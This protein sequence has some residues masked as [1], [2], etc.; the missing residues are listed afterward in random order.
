MKRL[1]AIFVT[2]IMVTTL[3]VPTLS[4]LAEGEADYSDYVPS[5]DM[6]TDLV[7]ST[8]PYN[9]S[10][11][12]MTFGWS[13]VNS[14]ETQ[15]AATEDISCSASSYY[16]A[17]GTFIKSDKF[18]NGGLAANTSYVF[19]AKIK[20][21]GAEGTA[22]KFGIWYWGTSAKAFPVEYG[23]AGYAPGSEF[24]DY[25]VTI[26]TTDAGC[27]LGIGMVSAKSGDILQLDYSHGIYFAE[28]KE[29]EVTN[30]VVGSSKVFAGSSAT[31]DAKV[32]NQIGSTGTLNQDMSF[33]ALDAERTAEV[34]GFEFTP[35]DDGTTN[36][37][38]ADTVAVGTYVILAK[39][40]EYAGFQKGVTI[41][42]VSADAYADSVVGDMP[43]DLITNTWPFGDITV[44]MSFAWSNGYGSEAQW[45]ANSDMAYTAT[46]QT[47]SAG[48][49]TISSS[50]F[51]TAT[52]LDSN[53]SYVFS[54]KFKN[55]G[56]EGTNPTFQLY[57]SGNQGRAFST[58][59]GSEGWAPGREFEDYK[60]SFNTGASTSGPLVLGFVTASTG[61][62]IQMDWSEGMY[63]SEEAAYEL[64]NEITGDQMVFAG[65]STTLK[66]EVL[67]QLGIPGTLSQDVDYAVLNA[68]KTAFA[69]GITVTA[70]GDGTAKV[71][72]AA[73]AAAGTY[74][75]VA[76]TESGL[77]KSAQLDVVSAETFA[78]KTAEKPDNFVLAPANLTALVGNNG[79]GGTFERSL[80]SQQIFGYLENS[81][82]SDP[83]W[84]AG[85]TLFAE[86]YRNASFV[87]GKNYVVS[88]RLKNGAPDRK[89]TV[90]AAFAYAAN[91]DPAVT[92]DVSN[93]E[94]ETYASTFTAT[95]D[96][97]GIHFGLSAR[98][99]R[100]DV[101]DE[102]RG[103]LL[104]DYS[105]GGSL[106]V[107]EEVAYEVVN[108]ITGDAELL[109]GSS[110]T[111]KTEVL[112]QVGIK[113]NLAQDV[114]YVA[115]T[116][117]RAAFAEGITVTEGADGAATVEVASSVA[118]G[119][120]VIYAKHESGI[121]TGIEIEV[122]TSKARV[123]A[124]TVAIEGE[125]AVFSAATVN[126][127][128]CANVMFVV[129]SYDAASKK[130]IK[131]VSA[132]AAVADGTAVLDE[133]L[134]VTVN[135]ADLVRVFA[136]DADTLAPI[137]FAADVDNIWDVE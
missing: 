48:G 72:V 93:T 82:A 45:K 99:D 26:T 63:L 122:V 101:T 116:A 39:A 115:L 113:G 23:A 16:S 22:P 38:I 134:T 112:N 10:T 96:G 18:T 131:A 111:L 127:A 7:T 91:M 105:N 15:W 51:T 130:L 133:E 53:K 1:L 29:W 36:V 103:L 60:I 87:T 25:N 34:E 40:T 13:E 86:N 85:P 54:A 46:T 109:A 120:Y 27:S 77:V 128:K 20:N 70:N 33:I 69:E 66:T 8:W 9:G 19:S 81:S 2:I 68:D 94:F 65:N 90:K 67:N 49:P 137:K 52:A 32:V 14:G 114:T 37:A 124:A 73:T 71:D 11:G 80:D 43:A 12:H 95:K 31:I 100:T 129:A 97:S 6:P 136:W 79:A 30:E 123:N 78:D 84:G 106:Y 3:F 17:M 89:A 92:W 47:W 64:V 21:A 5:G 132:V 83:Y 88:A 121:G 42:V 35:N 98:V 102:T 135:G 4:V 59:Y 126:G 57:Y 110:T 117:D 56:A 28:E 50:K 44:S 41:D 75:I 119:T 104:Y 61:D 125:N 118:P 24:E 58:E 62:I 74:N 107:A 55:A 108:E 76:M